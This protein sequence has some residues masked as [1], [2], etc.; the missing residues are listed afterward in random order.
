MQGGK[1]SA[2]IVLQSYEYTGMEV[3]MLLRPVGRI[4][5]I[6][7]WWSPIDIKAEN[8]AEVILLKTTTLTNSKNVNVGL[9]TEIIDQFVSNLVWWQ[10]FL[11]RIVRVTFTFN[12]SHSY[13]RKQKLLRSFFT[14]FSNDLNKLWC[15]A[16]T[17]WSVQ[18]YANLFFFF[19]SHDEYSRDEC[20]LADFMKNLS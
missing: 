13:T 19:F 7:I 5:L 12:Q 4:N 14:N 16:M 9:G 6:F 3:G 20:Y 15:A 18:T 10:I 17:C 2:A 1:I 11:K 8:P